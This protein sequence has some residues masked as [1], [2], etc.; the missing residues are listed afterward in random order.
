MS[1]VYEDRRRNLLKVILQSGRY[2][3]QK[4]ITMHAG[5]YQPL[6][7]GRKRVGSIFLTKYLTLIS[8][9]KSASSEI[10]LEIP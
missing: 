9:A 7:V 4:L 1:V 2:D 5:T 8:N 10:S 3:P 6:E